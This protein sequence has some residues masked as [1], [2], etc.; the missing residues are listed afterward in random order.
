MA[1][2]SAA[3]ETDV[4]SNAAKTGHIETGQVL[5]KGMTFTQ[6]VKALLFRPVPATLDGCLST[7]KRCGVRLDKGEHNLHGYPQRQR[8]N[9]KGVL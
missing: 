1:S 6:F 8:C 5:V 4:T 9:D 2:G 3:L 7:A